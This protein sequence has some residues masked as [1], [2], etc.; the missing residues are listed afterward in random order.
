MQRYVKYAASSTTGSLCK[1]TGYRRTFSIKTW[2]ETDGLAGPRT[3]WEGSLQCPCLEAPAKCDA[4]TLA[5]CDS[6]TAANGKECCN[7]ARA[8]ETGTGSVYCG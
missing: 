3:D 1:T 5:A 2:A 4:G 7:S 6:T 8:Q